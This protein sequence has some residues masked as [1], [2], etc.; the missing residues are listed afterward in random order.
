MKMKLPQRHCPVCGNA[1]SVEVLHTQRFVLPLHHILPQ[2][3]D[4]VACCDCGFVYADTPAG[5]DVYDR[6]YADMSKYE[7]A[8]ISAD[9]ALFIDRAKWISTFFEA[10]NRSLLDVGCG[11]GQLLLELQKLGFSD[12]TALDPSQQCID[13]IA[14]QGIQGIVGSI[15]D[16][17]ASRRFDGVVLSGVLE[18][19]C[20][21]SRVMEKM[22]SFTQRGG[23]LFVAV[24]DASRYQDY[25]TTPYDYFNIEHINH[26]EETSLVHLG[27][28][29]GFRVV[30][31]LK[32]LVTFFPI[33]QPMIFCAYCNENQE[34]VDWK[35]YAKRSVMRYVEKTSQ[36]ESLGHIL[37]ELVENQEEIIV[38]GA[39]NYTSRL[40][41]TTNLGQCNIAMFVDNDR[42][43]QGSSF[44]GKAVYAPNRI[45]ELKTTPKILI[46]AAVYY[47]EIIA[48][49]ERMGIK[50]PRVVLK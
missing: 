35:D 47:D 44:H 16:A 9:T 17:D 18:H 5:Q 20:D 50:N 48:E 41:A 13:A 46:C 1:A 21:V 12:L 36:A 38:W 4:V 42:H 24:P 29:H 23:L 2:E 27:L 43:K 8:Y 39:G 11:N 37:N 32:T 40:L 45:A 19:I 3:Y 26:F 34:P 25:D 6:Y 49:I 7:T 33:Q 15:F 22:K 14:A 31:F 28:R 10:R 30:G